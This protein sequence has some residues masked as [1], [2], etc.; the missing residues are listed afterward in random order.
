VARANDIAE[1]VERLV[2]GVVET[3]GLNLYDVVFR[4]SGPRWKL[5]VFIDRP[6]PGVSLDDCALVSRQI[7]R[8]LDAA[9]PVP[10]AYDL[11][12]SSPGMDRTL[13]RKSHWDAAEGQLVHVSTRDDSGRSRKF[14]ARVVASGEDAVELAPEGGEDTLRVRFTSILSARIKPEF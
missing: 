11:E 8:E 3:A 2:E 9:D 6:G 1:T 5:Q 4:Q 10:H 7:S 14:T 12:V 13:R